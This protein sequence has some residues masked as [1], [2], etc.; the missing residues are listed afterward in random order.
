VVALSRKPSNF[1]SS[2]IAVNSLSSIL[3]NR[4]FR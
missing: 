2:E 1:Q 4:L 3:A